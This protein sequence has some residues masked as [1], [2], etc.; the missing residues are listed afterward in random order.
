MK[1]PC[2]DCNT[3]T[4]LE[5]GFEVI[6]FVCPVCQSLYARDNEGKFRR[7]SQYKTTIND[8]PLEIGDVGFLKGSEYKVTGILVKN[9]HPDYRWTEFILQNHENEFLYL[10]LSNGHWILLTEMEE[11]FHVKDHPLALEHNGEDY[12]IF[13]YSDAKIINAQGFFDFEL[14][15]KN[16]IHL[17]EYI[18]PPFLISVERLHGVETSFYGEYIKKEEIK[19]AFKNI[20]LPHQFGVNMVQPGRFDLRNTAIIFCFIALLIITANWAIYKDQFQQNVFSDIVKFSEFDNKEITTN[21]FILN[22]GSA[23]LT[24]KVATDVNNS[25]ANL[26]VALVNEE[27]NDEIY[28][29]KDIELYHGYSDGESW[30]EGSGSEEFNICGVKAGKYHLLLTPMKAPEDTT[31]AEMRINVVW[32]EPSSRN[33]W[34]VIIGMIVIYL[35]IRFFRYSLEKERW[36]DSSYSRYDE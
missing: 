1:I 20:T 33:A 34:M 36:A 13:E 31:N 15:Q 29:N 26:N 24:V 10:S 11:V 21:S 7:K 18:K 23:P 25:W 16:A 28:A 5:V 17:V 30:T 4:E 6:N 9:V 27:T 2:Y 8:F 12:D 35:I 3:E 19:K 22:G 14:P 32:N